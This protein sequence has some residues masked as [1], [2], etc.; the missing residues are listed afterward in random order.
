MKINGENNQNLGELLPRLEATLSTSEFLQRIRRFSELD[1]ENFLVGNV[2]VDGKSYPVVVGEHV[3]KRCAQR[4]FLT[5][6]GI[7]EKAIRWLSS[8]MVGPRVVEDPVLW[9]E[10]SHDVVP[11]E[12]EGHVGTCL[13]LEEEYLILIF[14][15]GF[16]YIRV[17]TIYEGISDFKSAHDDLKLRVSKCGAIQVVE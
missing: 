15:A 17:K 13:Q 16:N 6:E 9:D 1:P 14:E 3:R 10:E 4:T 8:P 5:M 11:F 7:L 2:V 12:E